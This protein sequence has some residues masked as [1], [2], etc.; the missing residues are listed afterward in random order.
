MLLRVYLAYQ[1]VEQ[2]TGCCALPHAAR[3]CR[4]QMRGPSAV[5]M[6]I[7]FEIKCCALKLCT[8][9][10]VLLHSTWPHP[11]RLL[12]C[13]ISHSRNLNRLC[14]ALPF[15]VSLHSTWPHRK[16]V[17][18]CLMLACCIPNNHNPYRLC[19]AFCCLAPL[20]H[21]TTQLAQPNS[22]PQKHRS[23]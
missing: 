20:L 7:G 14:A 18:P 8:P 23:P 12:P 5:H 16:Q 1:S 10:A 6:A 4:E 21:S 17:V 15:D 2:R 11:S 9:A 13:S 19:T 3:K 22:P